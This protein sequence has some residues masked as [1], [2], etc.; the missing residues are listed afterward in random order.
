[1][2]LVDTSVWRHALRRTRPRSGPEA[3]QWDEAQ[4][5]PALLE[6]G[7]VIAHL[8]VHTELLLGGMPAD[9]SL[10]YGRLQRCRPVG[11]S[12]LF[13]LVQRTRPRGIGLVDVGLLGAALRD[14]LLVWTLDGALRRAAADAG[15]A[16]AP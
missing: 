15:V 8:W 1:M 7:R 11:A 4:L 10:L 3:E 13:E 12:V 16:Y 14:G 6:Q 9:A 2:I 5:L